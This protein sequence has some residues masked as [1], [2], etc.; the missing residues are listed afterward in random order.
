MQDIPLIL[1]NAK[2]YSRQLEVGHGNKFCCC[3][4]GKLIYG[5]PNS[6]FQKL[7]DT[8][9]SHVSDE[10][11]EECPKKKKG[12]GGILVRKGAPGSKKE[13]HEVD[14]GSRLAGKS[15]RG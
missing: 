10:R 8:N 6:S 11:R 9:S 3:D 4:Q 1:N 14:F 7:D 13:K 15:F 2:L 12:K 5:P